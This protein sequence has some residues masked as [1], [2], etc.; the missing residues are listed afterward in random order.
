M[1]TQ[2][3]DSL[4]RYTLMKRLATGGMGEVYLAAKAG[5]VGFGPRV[6]LKILRD[7]LASDQQFVD[8]LVDEANIS[9]FL[10]HQNVV[11][12]LDLSE[13]QGRYY[14]AMEFVQGCTVESLIERLIQKGRK[15]HVS[16][17]LFIGTELCRALKYAHTRVNH[18]GEPLNIIHRDVTPANILLSIQGEVK[19]TDFGIARAKGRIHQTQAG[20]L[21]G[22]FGYMAPEMIRYE[23]IDARADLF[24]AG[25][26]IYL[27]IT[28]RHPVAGANV[29]EAIARYE[30]KQIPKPSEVNPEI[31]PSLDQIVMRALEPKVENRWASAAALGAALQDAVLKVPQWRREVQDGAQ[32][33]SEVL[34]EVFPEAFTD[35]IS[36]DLSEKLLRDALK[37][38]GAQL[39]F[40]GNTD[41]NEES[42]E[43]QMPSGPKP[44]A[45][46]AGLSGPKTD[47]EM[48]P[49]KAEPFDQRATAGPE[50]DE[51]AFAETA[52]GSK[53]LGEIA[54]PELETE[55]G[56]HLE[57][58]YAV[59]Q[60]LISESKKSG[61]GLVRQGGSAAS[62][63]GVHP[64]FDPNIDEAPTNVAPDEPF[65]DTVTQNNDKMGFAD[66]STDRNR[67]HDEMMQEQELPKGD[68]KPG[69]PRASFDWEGRKYEQRPTPMEI[70]RPVPS[71]RNIEDGQTIV[72]MSPLSS[73]EPR[74]KGARDTDESL[75]PIVEPDLPPLP[76]RPDSMDDGKT[77]AGMVIPDWD[78]GAD[79]SGSGEPTI[80]G[81]EESRHDPDATRA[82]ASIDQIY[83][84]RPRPDSD[85]ATV[86][87]LGDSPDVDDA[88]DRTILD[89]LDARSV[90]EEIAKRRRADEGKAK[91]TLKARD[92]EPI[93]SGL[94]KVETIEDKRAR[95]VP[96]ASTAIPADPD[97]D[98]LIADAFKTGKYQAPTPV[99]PQLPQGPVR[100]LI[101]EDGAPML[102]V[103]QDKPTNEEVAILP[104]G[105][106]P[107][108]AALA[109]NAQGADAGLRKK[110]PG[111][112]RE[113]K[114]T[115][116]PVDK[117]AAQHP[118][119][120]ADADVGM[121]TGR[122]I[123]GELSAEALS[124][125][126]DAA[127]RRAVA[128]RHKQ[129]GG[130]PPGVPG[131]GTTPAQSVPGMAPGAPIPGMM[132]G[133][134]MPQSMSMI[135]T[136]VRYPGGMVGP[137]GRIIPTI[138]P[139]GQD[140]SRTVLLVSLL[141]GVFVMVGA[142]FGVAFFTRLLWPKLKLETDPPG[143]TVVV[144]EVVADQVAPVMVKVAPGQAHIVELRLEGYRS[145]RREISDGVG[146]GRTYTLPVP[147]K[148][149]TPELD[150]R[151]VE[152]TVFVNG[153][154]AGQGTHVRLD[155]LPTSG[156][157]Q[158]KV[159][160]EGRKPWALEFERPGMIPES[161]DI[162]LAEDP[163]QAALAPPKTP[164][165]KR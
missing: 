86:I 155:K 58:V 63:A 29:M 75:S 4:G 5:P 124:W 50:V 121:Q 128:T 35:P 47:R 106:Q 84:T 57:Q 26:V 69:Q 156:V 94:P 8:M 79:R 21:K 138:M 152:G 81:A 123:A 153:Q 65:L 127:A 45:R 122:W 114:R 56:L 111:A 116:P 7:E 52:N 129:P 148:R 126:D 131:P 36:P 88:G 108:A 23:Q 60:E 28:G 74:V 41:P 42:G 144:D 118:P 64:P 49:L 9:M 154:K 146:R 104:A 109:A 32:Q 91:T 112:A 100:I 141:V 85:S 37:R 140:R 10:N 15:L 163:N 44:P 164:Q 39:A 98:K 55:Q 117:L 46:R 24:C 17:G 120:A 107:A 165:K 61:K 125:D 137:D 92:E 31:P 51:S 113:K 34:R 101:G 6:A 27:M 90:A 119:I 20:V 22:K 158:I 77:V 38:N 136:G 16:H 11:S 99:A 93:K 18:A 14:I 95:K 83:G 48:P 70:E 150:I 72:G 97:M 76:D 54:Q 66:S 19:L 30:E 147:L 43:T 53:K 89:G 3:G 67:L 105:V 157:I 142:A 160:A 115:D 33:L 25:V 130:R 80:M 143:A 132:P 87:P 161:I 145:E 13:D 134:M 71:M 78:T 133:Q 40:E 68:D 135:G 139:V 103:P 12:V 73:I 159:E 96:E 59:K 1:P 2:I 110:G 151:P 149:I 82:Y 62:V 102:D 162:P